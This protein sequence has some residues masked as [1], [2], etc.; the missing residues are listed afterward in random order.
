MLISRPAGKE[1]YLAFS[2]TLNDVKENEPVEVDFDGVFVFSPSWGAE[3]LE[4]LR[5]R[6]GDRVSYVNADNA[7]VKVTLEVLKEAERKE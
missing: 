3:F 5:A 7:S 4:P 2:P 6:F 1:A